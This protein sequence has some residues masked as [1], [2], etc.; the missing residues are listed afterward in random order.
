MKQEIIDYFIENCFLMSPDIIDNIKDANLPKLFINSINN[1]E[2]SWKK[3]TVVNKDLFLIIP[4][5]RNKI[6]I[7]WNEFENSR[8][9][10]EHGRNDKS[11]NLFLDIL[12]YNLEDKK[13]NNQ[14]KP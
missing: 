2:D 1:N 14:T 9:M 7:N 8:V 6:E 11:Y 12:N 5:I 10:I 4:K 13:K 3:I